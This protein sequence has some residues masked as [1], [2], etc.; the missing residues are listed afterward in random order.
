MQISDLV[1]AVRH[2]SRLRDF[3]AVVFEQRAFSPVDRTLEGDLTRL[4]I[5]FVFTG[6]YSD[7]SGERTAASAWVMANPL[8]SR[9]KD[10]PG[11]LENAA[12]ALKDELDF[13]CQDLSLVRVEAM[14]RDDDPG[15]E[16]RMRLDLSILSLAAVLD[17][18]GAKFYL[19]QVAENARALTDIQPDRA[20]NDA[21]H[22]ETNHHFSIDAQGVCP[23]DPF[24][25]IGQ[26]FEY[27]TQTM[28]V[29]D[30]SRSTEP[31]GWA[32]R[33]SARTFD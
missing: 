22:G 29:T 1:S 18:E 30:F 11:L 4:R 14:V 31:G 32:V 27:R 10:D 24:M 16:Y 9:G 8:V 25:L 6:L 5:M 13:L 17:V 23:G 7:A 20:G 3:N 19:T 2:S 15:K 33:L 28:F 21:W 12:A 26:A